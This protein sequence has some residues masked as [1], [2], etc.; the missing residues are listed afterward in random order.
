[1]QAV[2]D[3][4]G[5]TWDIESGIQLSTGESPFLGEKWVRLT[6][7][8]DSTGCTVEINNQLAT[9]QDASTNAVTVTKGRFTFSTIPQYFIGPRMDISC[10]GCDKFVDMSISV[11]NLI[12]R[13]GTSRINASWINK[14]LDSITNTSYADFSIRQPIW[15]PTSN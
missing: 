1:M 7:Y 3:A 2:S 6:M 8:F 9:G 11:K 10:N 14:T 4:L 5:A 12:V 15:R 13:E